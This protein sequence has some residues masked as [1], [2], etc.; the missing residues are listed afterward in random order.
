MRARAE[1][2]FFT[3][4]IFCASSNVLLSDTL[5]HH[6]SRVDVLSGSRSVSEAQ[7]GLLHLQF[8]L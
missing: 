1:I 3:V 7:V 6:V 5:P 4:S 2:S 8:L